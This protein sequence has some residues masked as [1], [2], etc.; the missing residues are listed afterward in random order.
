MSS[1]DSDAV[2]AVEGRVREKGA[3]GLITETQLGAVYC[4]QQTKYQEVLVA[5]GPLGRTLF[6]DGNTQSCVTDEALYHS[7]LVHPAM[8]SH[9]C[10]KRVLIGGG[11][12]GGTLRE[13]LRHPDV[14]EANMVDIDEEAVQLFRTHLPEMGAD[15]WHDRRA[16]VFYDDIR[17]WMRGRAESSVDVVILDLGDPIQGGPSQ[18]GFTEDFYRECARIMAPGGVLVT[19]AGEFT[20][21]D[22]AN[23]RAILAS[24]RKSFAELLP[25]SAYIP[26]FAAEWGFFMASDGTLPAVPPELEARW[27]R[28][29]GETWPAYDPTGHA[30]W[31][32][33]PPYMR[34][35]LKD[36]ALG[37]SLRDD[38]PLPQAHR[39]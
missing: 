38:A 6:L 11:G 10:P 32:W 23:F 34:A 26:S 30:A 5:E 3:S 28:A 17:T 13:V 8:F 22:T 9:P 37:P 27:R 14:V 19:Q 18:L 21:D 4:R 2:P 35:R 12:E 1:R 7:A 39:A 16:H 15:A 33:L 29:G 31:T 36:S 20:Y 24:A 25:F